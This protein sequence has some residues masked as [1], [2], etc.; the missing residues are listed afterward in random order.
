MSYGF[1]SV[2]GYFVTVSTQGKWVRLSAPCL[3]ISQPDS[4]L[5]MGNILECHGKMHIDELP[6]A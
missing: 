4:C 1:W 2:Q 6:N 3:R 5:L